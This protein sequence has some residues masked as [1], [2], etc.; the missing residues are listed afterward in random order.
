MIPD[1][2]KRSVCPRVL[3]T[4]VPIAPDGNGYFY[5]LSSQGSV[6]VETNVTHSAFTLGLMSGR[7]FPL[8]GL[9]YPS[10]NHSQLNYVANNF[11][12]AP[13]LIQPTQIHEL[14]HSL[15]QI[16]SGSAYGSSEASANR[17]MQCVDNRVR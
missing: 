2:G 9:T 14:A 10:T 3:R 8:A 15:D 1:S 7:P 17:L 13:G 16:K 5:G 6:T 11:S 4:F 12:E